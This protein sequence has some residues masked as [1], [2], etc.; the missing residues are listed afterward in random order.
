[1]RYSNGLPTA[2]E[3]AAAHP[4]L[5]DY[6]RVYDAIPDTNAAILANFAPLVNV[7]PALNTPRD[8]PLAINGTYNDDGR[9][10]GALLNL[11]WN[12]ISGPGKVTFGD[13]QAASTTATFAEAGSYVLRLTVNDGFLYGFNELTVIVI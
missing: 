9:P 13:E 12:K 8:V 10:A 6:I 7:G 3:L 11:R 1:M 2:E 4:F 5:V